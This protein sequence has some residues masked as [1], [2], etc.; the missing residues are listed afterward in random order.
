MQNNMAIKTLLNSMIPSELLEPNWRLLSFIV[1][2][3]SGIG[4]L[5]LYPMSEFHGYVDPFYAPTVLVVPIAGLFRLTCYAYRKDYHR[6]VF[7]HP[8]A[9]GINI[10]GDSMT[11]DYSGE[12]KFFRV[13]NLHRY[14]LYVGILILPFFYYD[15]YISLIYSGSFVLRLGSLLLLLNAVALT[16]WAASC[17]ALRHLIGGRTDCYGCAFA[18]SQRKS[19]FNWQSILNGHH[20]FF[21]WFS[22]LTIIFVDLYL[23]GLA[24]GMPIDLNLS[25]LL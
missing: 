25:K 10:R 20:E 11:R 15:F 16:L 18:G 8:N 14:F 4:V 2:L 21:A 5:M 13:E 9:C 19:L 6:H 3:I 24:A 1:L 17:H 22:L 12:T 7:N 23:R